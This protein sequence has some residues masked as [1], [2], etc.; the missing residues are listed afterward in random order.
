MDKEIF[1]TDKVVTDKTIKTE[2][3]IKKIIETIETTE[4]TETTE[5]IEITETTETTETTE[6]TE[7]TEIIEIIEVKDTKRI[8]NKVIDRSDNINQEDRTET[9]KEANIDKD[10]IEIDPKQISHLSN[11]SDLNKNM[12]IIQTKY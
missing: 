5:T 10:K 6:I 7:I 8:S 4:T 9:I 12:Y 11:R 2:T 1:R 3:E